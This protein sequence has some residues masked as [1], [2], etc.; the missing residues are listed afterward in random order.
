MLE[1]IIAFQWWDTIGKILLNTI[2]V[3]IPEELYLLMFT[4]ILV[5][6]FEIWGDENCKKIFHDY[7]LARILVPV[8]SAALL[9]N[10]FRYC[11]LDN[12]ILQI[13]PIIVFYILIV[14]TNDIFG[15]S[16]AAKWMGKVFLFLGLAFLILVLAEFSFA[17]LFLYVSGKTVTEMNSNILLN[18]AVSIPPRIIEYS[19]LIF[20]IVRKRTLLKANLIIPILESKISLFLT[21]VVLVFDLAFMLIMIRIVT[22]EKI[23]NNISESFRIVIILG[24][25]FFLLINLSALVWGF[26][27]IKNRELQDKKDVSGRINDL[28]KEINTYTVTDKYDS[29][30]WK[31]YE[32]SKE[33]NEISA[34]LYNSRE[35]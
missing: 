3:S 25:T 30:K 21:I 24:I 1:T 26:Y 2:L 27:N 18:F 8:I 29:I 17:T 13:V 16:S 31:L 20:F 15:D 6:E 11:E 7:D 9:S 5:G 34:C 28:V 10:I 12:N 35:K 4:L 19:V 14:L 22:Y 33:M 32:I 23:L